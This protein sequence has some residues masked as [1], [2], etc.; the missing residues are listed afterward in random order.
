MIS[1]DDF[2]TALATDLTKS[3]TKDQRKHQ[4]VI[5]MQTRMLEIK[6]SLGTVSK[7]EEDSLRNEMAALET[8]IARKTEQLERVGIPVD[9]MAVA[10][11]P[12]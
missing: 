5:R 8:S 11:R 2:L 7:D 10:P 1:L 6:A 3:K 12:T 9:A 4:K